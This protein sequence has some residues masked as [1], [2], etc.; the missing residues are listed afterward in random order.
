MSFD[1]DWAT[2]F[3]HMIRLHNRAS[4]VHRARRSVPA[5]LWMDLDPAT[6]GLQV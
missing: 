1:G 2:A 3:E 4:T 5:P 6:P